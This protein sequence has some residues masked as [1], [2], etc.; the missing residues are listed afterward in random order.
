MTTD[1]VQEGEQEGTGEMYV[2]VISH[3]SFTPPS[4]CSSISN[5]IFHSS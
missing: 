2:V 5:F 3:D 4:F 1:H